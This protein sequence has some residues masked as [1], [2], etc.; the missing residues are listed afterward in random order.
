M[1]LF[2]VFVERAEKQPEHPL[3]ITAWEEITYRDFQ[4]RIEGVVTKLKA[5]GIEAGHCIGL[6]Y[7]NSPE[8][9]GLT[10]A[11]WGCGAS[12]VPIP[13]ELSTPEKEQ[14]FHNICIDA[15][16][17]KSDILQDIEGTW[18]G[19]TLPIAQ[20]SVLISARRFREPPAGL[21]NVNP[22]FVRFSSGTT[23]AA[24]GVVLSH[25]TIYERIQAANEGLHLGP[26]DR[27]VWLLSMAY[28]F[29][30]SI[31][32]YLSFGATILLCP[33][34]FGSTIVRLAA[35]QK[36]TVIYAAPI[37]Y[38]LMT[39]DRSKRLLPNLRLAIVTTTALSP[40][41]ATAFYK[42]F[43]MALN[44]TY[45][46]IEVGL[47]AI[48]LERPREKQGSV[49]RVLPA[50][51]LRLEAMNEAQGLGAI[52]LRGR[53]LVDA[54]YEPW[55]M[56]DQILAK[57]GGWF[58]T[59][60]LGELDEDGYLFI[61]GRSKEVISVGGMKFFPQEVEAVLE[62][63]PAIEEACVFR[64]P[65]KRLGDVPH[66][67]MVKAAGITQLPTE[68]ELKAFCTEQVALHKVPAQFSFVPALLRTASG[69]VVR[70]AAKILSQ[71]MTEA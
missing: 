45:G 48:N 6:H 20:E 2:D 52:Q 39:H 15:V 71:G 16:I 34:T 53:G 25:E 43:Q 38:A 41:V 69:K 47:P 31:V 17:S 50:Y 21:A 22:A 7:P 27:I 11:I 54:Y 65:D 60:D 14:I 67:L 55:Q 12:V 46:I 57:N 61:R 32:S 19:T 29:A 26:D 63:H 70:N 62:T 4:H 9:I 24:K 5:H 33:N 13:V 23:G 68:D 8:Y 66:A 1:N 58:A 64:Y 3:I 35:K 10:Y 37:H 44:E 56:R 18:D 59:G 40:D 51:D 36:A 42:R 49:G 30:V 28:H